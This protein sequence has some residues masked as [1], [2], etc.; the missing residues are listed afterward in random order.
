MALTFPLLTAQ[1]FGGLL[2]A[3]SRL[4]LSESMEINRTAGGEVLTADLGPRLWQGSITLTPNTH[5]AMAQA[6]ARLST[7]RQA[8]RAFYMYDGRK[9]FPAADP[10]GSI[11][12]AATPTLSVVGANRRDITISGL[13]ANYVLSDGDYLSFIYNTS[14]FALHQIVQGATASGAGLATVEVTPHIRENF[15][16]TAVT[17][18]RPYC[19]AVVLPGSY[20]P[21]SGGLAISGGLGFSCIQTLAT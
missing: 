15:S 12:G 2:V 18:I 21:S 11:L 8:G 20:A 7:L 19:K 9:Q 14:R 16:L 13:P 4:S 10:T 6:E 17:L 5:A 3:E 1:F